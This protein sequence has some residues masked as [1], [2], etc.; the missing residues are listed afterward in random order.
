[1]PDEEVR[2][3]RRG[4]GAGILLLPAAG[5][6]ASGIIY[7]AMRSKPAKLCG[8]V[9]DK[10]T[11]SPIEGV[12]VT[13]DGKITHTNAYGYYEL[14]NLD[15]KQY[16]IAFEKDGYVTLYGTV[17]LA[18][19]DNEVSVE[20]ESTGGGNGG[21]GNL[22]YMS[23]LIVDPYGGPNDIRWTVS[24]GNTGYEAAV[25][26]LKIYERMQI[27]QGIEWSGFSER[28]SQEATIA[29]SETH[30]FTGT[31]T[32]GPYVYQL[33]SKCEA[34]TLL[35]PGQPLEYICTY[36]QD[37]YE[38]TIS[39][40][41]V[42]ELA[43]HIAAVHPQYA[44]MDPCTFFTVRGT[45]WPDH[46]VSEYWVNPEREDMGRITKWQAEIFVGSPALISAIDD[47]EFDLSGLKSGW[48][49]ASEPIQ[50]NMPAGWVTSGRDEGGRIP[51]TTVMKLYFQTDLG[52]SGWLDYSPW[53]LR[54]PDG[55]EITFYCTDIRTEGWT[56]T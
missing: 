25:C 3:K 16:D 1:M 38:T 39:F 30:T 34:G 26:H 28:A 52:W 17:S 50:F 27:P 20:L 51:N 14:A 43:D 46:F 31:K 54:I 53:L 45:S 33:M 10:E 42:E 9:T 6:A 47:Q 7:V 11:F 18:A 56:I 22:V 12:K 40:A 29:P 23:G 35:N 5:L 19:G 44:P 15:T 4:P 24:V 48:M 2:T 49:P 55:A 21:P 32:R 13:L 36:C 8:V 41:T 37:L